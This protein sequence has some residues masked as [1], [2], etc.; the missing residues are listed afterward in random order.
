[1]QN[2]CLRG[3]SSAL[4]WYVCSIDRLGVEYAVIKVS[5]RK[6]YDEVEVPAAFGIVAGEM[7]GI[8]LVSAI[9]I[10]RFVAL[11]V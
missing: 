8:I 1:M 11:G 4:V 2:H 3:V 9:N 7:L 10:V 6:V 5:G